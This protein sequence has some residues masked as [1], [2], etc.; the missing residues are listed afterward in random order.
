MQPS[1][2]KLL[3]Y[4]GETVTGKFKSTSLFAPI[5]LVLKNKHNF[6]Q[7][8]VWSHA[9]QFEVE[10]SRFWEV[11]RISYKIMEKGNPSGA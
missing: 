7:T 9:S 1:G 8:E 10:C 2:R 11:L 6:T 3:T 4:Q 5:F